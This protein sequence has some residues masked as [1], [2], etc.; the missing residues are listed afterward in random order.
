[1]CR[2]VVLNAIYSVRMDQVGDV[3]VSTFENII[4][5]NC[6]LIVSDV[7]SGLETVL[8]GIPGDTFFWNI[9]QLSVVRGAVKHGNIW[10]INALPL[11]R[12][13]P[14]CLLVWNLS[15]GH[16]YIVRIVLILLWENGRMN[17][18]AFWVFTKKC[19]LKLRVLFAFVIQ[20]LLLFC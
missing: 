8:L 14:P 11:E 17:L 20:W 6:G 13:A 9:C 3:A 1:M 7:D 12:R 10:K 18:Y 16:I 2:E 4:I 19:Y 15:L 5:M